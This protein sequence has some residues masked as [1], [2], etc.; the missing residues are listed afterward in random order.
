MLRS[1]FG[2]HT[3]PELLEG[4]SGIEAH[5]VYCGPQD[6]PEMPA[7]LGRDALYLLG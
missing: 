3:V 7:L 5:L 4:T 2:S 1:L 6:I